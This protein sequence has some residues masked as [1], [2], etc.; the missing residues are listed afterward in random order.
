VQVRN[1]SLAIAFA[2]L[3]AV[4]AWGG[5]SLALETPR[6]AAEVAPRVAAELQYEAF[7]PPEC[8]H[9]A[10]RDALAQRAPGPTC[11]VSGLRD[12]PF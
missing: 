3:A 8:R 11:A 12:A 6:A 7:A 2:A 10:A 4:P 5:F 9:R 1:I